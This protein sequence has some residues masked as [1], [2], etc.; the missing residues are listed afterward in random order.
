MSSSGKYLALVSAIIV[1]VGTYIIALMGSLGYAS[2]GIGFFQ[3]ISDNFQYSDVYALGVG[4]DSW[5][6]YLTLVILIIFALSGIFLLLGMK[7]RIASILGAICPLI[8][9]IIYL[10]ATAAPDIQ[11]TLQLG[12]LIGAQTSAPQIG[13]VFPV[14]VNMGDYSLGTILILSGAVLAIIAAVLPRE[15]SY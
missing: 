14:V 8:V 2:S 4:L 9:G 15:D 13:E 3:N 7:Y 10:L 11:I 12:M 5:Y 1:I 6:G